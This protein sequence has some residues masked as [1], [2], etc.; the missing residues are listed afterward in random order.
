MGPLLVPRGLL[1]KLAPTEDIRSVR[2]DGDKGY[3][4]T[5]KKTDPLFVIDLEDPTAP[6]VLGELKIPGFSTYMQKMDDH[7]ILTIGYGGDEQGSFAWFE[8]VMLQIF[9]VADPTDPQLKFK[10][11]IGTRGSSSEALNNHLAFTY[12]APKDIVAIPITV[13]EESQGGGSYGMNMTFS[14]LMVFNVTTA[15]GFSLRG[16]VPFPAADAQ[17]DPYGDPWADPYAG[18]MC[19]NWWTQASSEVKRSLIIDN[20]VYSISPTTL[21]VND[22]DDLAVDLVSLPLQ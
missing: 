9:D 5:F 22:L 16:Q 15:A 17:P 2:F 20:F 18:N 10:H 13:C 11:V 21:K 8:G 12:Y 1:D 6:A 7:H 4:V 3:V 19:T 14:G